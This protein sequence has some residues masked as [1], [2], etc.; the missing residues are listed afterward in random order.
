MYFLPNFFTRGLK[1]CA[2]FTYKHSIY[3]LSRDFPKDLRLRM[4]EFKEM[5]GN[6]LKF[7]E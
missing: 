3:E 4:L 6:C 2:K 1:R 5:S 7:I